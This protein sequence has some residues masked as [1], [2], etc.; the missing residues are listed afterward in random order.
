V[1]ANVFNALRPGGRFVAEQGGFGNVAAVVTA[2]NGGRL[3]RRLAAVMPWDF[4]SVAVATARLQ[5]AGFVV[6]SCALIHRPTALPTGMAGWL[7]SFAAPFL[8]GVED[9]AALLAQAEAALGSLRDAQGLWHA[10]YV[11]LRFAARRPA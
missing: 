8:T 4:P 11:R 2:L 10:D 3:A 6:E 5:A 1:V 9:P 7:R